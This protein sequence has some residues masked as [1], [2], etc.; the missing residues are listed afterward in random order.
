[1]SRRKTAKKRIIAQDPIYNSVLVSMV[2][3]RILLK[4]KKTIA[5]KIFYEAMKS[6]EKSN[7]RDPI[8]ILTKAVTN[9]TPLLEVRSRRVGGAVYQV[10]REVKPER[11][12]SLALRLIITAARERPGRGMVIK[13]GNEII[14]AYNYTGG[15][16]RKK[17]DMHKM[18]QAN[19]AFSNLRR[20]KK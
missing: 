3:N 5:Q 1:M 7:K 14:D 8:E 15:A 20:K 17:E 18:A 4:G 12:I 16:I 11:G 10:P 19:K 6:I 9:A 13:F 2:I